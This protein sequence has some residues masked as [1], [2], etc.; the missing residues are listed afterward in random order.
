MQNVTQIICVLYIRLRLFDS[1]GYANAWKTFNSWQADIYCQNMQMLAQGGKPRLIIDE[2]GVVCRNALCHGSVR[3]IV[4][5]ALYWAVLHN[6]Q[7]SITAGRTGTRLVYHNLR[8]QFH[9]S[10]MTSDAYGYLTS[11][12]FCRI[13]SPCQK[14]QWWMWLLSVRKL[15]NFM[16]I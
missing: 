13:H 15:L 2:N 10:H 12:E 8:R 11:C 6:G 1:S 9:W 16:T 7:F 5:E 3:V 14:R 4:M